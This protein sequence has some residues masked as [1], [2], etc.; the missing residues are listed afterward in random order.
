MGQ[1]FTNDVTQYARYQPDKDNQPPPLGK[2]VN[3]LAQI[4]RI[5]VIILQINI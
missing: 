1:V 5:F 4:N 3:I 2:Q